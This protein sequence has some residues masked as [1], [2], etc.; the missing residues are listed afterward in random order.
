VT[1]VLPDSPE[2][3]AVVERSA[4][5]DAAR[6]GLL[7]LASAHAGLATDLAADPTLAAAATTIACASDSLL[8]TL[9]AEPVALDLLRD[10][11]DLAIPRSRAQ[12][13]AGVLAALAADDDGL[14]ALRRWKRLEYFRVAARDLLGLADLRVVGR[15][16]SALAAA[17]LG[18]ALAI[19]APGT[20]M[21]VIGMGKLGGGELNY[22][23]DVDVMF[24]HSG[25]QG[26]AEA[27]ARRVL[28]A[29]TTPTADGIVFRTD[30]NLRPEGRSG[31]LSRSLDAYAAYWERWAHTWEYQALLKARPVAGDAALGAE[32]LARAQPHVWRERLDPGAV[33]EIR[34]MKERTEARVRAAGL[35]GRELKRG[36]GGIRDIEFSV[37]LLQLVHGR[38]DTSARSPNTLDALEALAA[39]GYVS[40][41]DAEALDGAYVW[42]RTVEH[43]LQLR[44][45]QQTHTLPDDPA[46]L[47]RL[48]RVLGFRDRG[49]TSALAA[50]EATQQ[51]RRSDVRAL[52]EKLFFAPLLETLAGAGQLSPEAAEDRLVAF[53]FSDLDQTRI[54]THVAIVMDG[55]GR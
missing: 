43:R 13:E 6:T 55:N 29:M 52:H 16:L 54:P 49:A 39:G 20:P 35:E 47:T 51:R 30:A 9:E 5:P 36:A 50:F 15:E 48:A 1:T 33:R 18:G 26:A 28:A 12:M 3:R 23:S 8:A 46:E 34:A 41:G 11:A 27:A 14:R 32:F 10:R 7:R 17:A 21:A 24:V 53:G 19:A 2:L 4:D 38:D 40:V 37:Q 45:D 22:S 25:E 44:N 42:L 31:A